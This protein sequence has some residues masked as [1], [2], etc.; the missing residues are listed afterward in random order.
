MKVTIKLFATLRNQRFKV[1]IQEFA[2]AVTV[3]NI[4]EKLGIDREEL[5]IVLVNGQDVALEHM[6]SDGDVLA[7]FPPVG[8]G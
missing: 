1:D 3:L 5:A 6:L 7:L 2:E 4:V 8:G